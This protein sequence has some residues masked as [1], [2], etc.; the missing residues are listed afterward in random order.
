[1]KKLDKA[2]LTELILSNISSFVNSSNVINGSDFIAVVFDIENANPKEQLQNG[3]SAIDLG[4]CTNTIK[5]YYK[6]DNFIIVNLESKNNKSEKNENDKSF[7]LGKTN[8]IELYDYSGKRL[9]LSICKEDIKIMKYIGDA[10]ELNIES[11]K[12]LSEQGIDV[13]NA[14]D[15]FFN[16][17]CHYYDNKD[18]K[19]IILNDRRTDIYQNATFCQSGCVYD[20]MDYELMA[21]NCICDTNVFQIND[22]NNTKEE[23]KGKSQNINFDN[24]KKSFISNIFD[25]NYEVIFCYNLV[26]NLKIMKA[27][28]GFYSMIIML[29]LQIMVLIIYI[30]K[31]LKGIRYDIFFSSSKNKKNNLS[32]PP[33]KNKK[34]SKNKINIDDRN[35]KYNYYNEIK[36]NNKEKIQ[37]MNDDLGDQKEII[38]INDIMKNKN[39]KQNI[40]SQNNIQTLNINQKIINIKSNKKKK[41]AENNKLNN[42]KYDEEPKD[43]NSKEQLNSKILKGKKDKQFNNKKR[44]LKNKKYSKNL[45]LETKE[46]KYGMKNKIKSKKIISNRLSLLDDELQDMEFNEAIIY[47]KRSYFRMYWSFLV[48][49][50]II[51]GTF[52]TKNY[53]HLFVIKLSFLIFNFEI[54]FFLN[55]FF[56]TDEYISDAYHNDGV[57]DFISGLPKS[58]YSFVATLITTNLLR[59]LSNSKSELQKVIKEKYNDK[60]YKFIINAKIKKLRNKLIIYFILVF[61]LGLF[62]SYYVSSFCAVY[63]N[64]QKYWFIGCFESFAIDSLVSFI[65]CLF[66]SFIRYVGIKRKIAC[67]YKT[68]NILSIFL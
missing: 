63:R 19:D 58:I 20:G 49:S 65:S 57:L 36:D 40:F 2:A 64:S 8:Q 45:I 12:D 4:N 37:F 46:E 66:L 52:C 53:L 15:K 26:I 25:F 55:A 18:G 61:L 17:L 59:M 47:D 56:Y 39:K 38:N 30:I 31:G 62:F 9:N 7:D 32:N 43:I 41:L 16:D 14:S 60:Y 34:N 3:I 24:L 11:A 68:S 21:A 27:N 33:P 10:E 6:I 67:L 51:L 44:K 5:D 48:D 1:M 13:F 29:S 22:L 42:F 50:H 28:I 23:E 35:K 54:N